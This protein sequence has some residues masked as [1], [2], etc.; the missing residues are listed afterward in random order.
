MNTEYNVCQCVNTMNICHCVFTYNTTI[1]RY[2]SAHTHTHLHTHMR[3][4]L[5][6]CSNEDIFLQDFLEIPKQ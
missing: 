2:N 1:C 3:V 6:T 5:L 4:A